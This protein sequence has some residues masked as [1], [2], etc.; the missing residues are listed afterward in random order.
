[1]IFLAGAVILLISFISWFSVKA[2]TKFGKVVKKG[3]LTAFGSS[4]SILLIIG[5]NIGLTASF[6]SLE[7]YYLA[8]IGAGIALIIGLALFAGQ[9]LSIKMTSLKITPRTLSW[10]D[11]STQGKINFYNIEDYNFVVQLDDQENIP[12]YG[13]HLKLNLTNG[14]SRKICISCWK[15]PGDLGSSRHIQTILLHYL[16]QVSEIKAQQEARKKQFESTVILQDDKPKRRTYRE[17]IEEAKADPELLREQEIRQQVTEAQI[18]EVSDLINAQ[19]KLSVSWVSRVTQLSEDLVIEIA[20]VILGKYYHNGFIVSDNPSEYLEPQI[21]Y[22]AKK[23]QKVKELVDVRK[24]IS[25]AWLSKSTGIPE[26][27]VVD[28]ATRLLGRLF[29]NGYIISDDIF[30]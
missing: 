15:T 3:A 8:L 21:N 25:V 17:S 14:T 1:M 12:E 23:I 27:Q 7:V 28:I 4:A 18:S 19:K 13:G 16:N 5:S 11:G 2:S 26:H 6:H 30:E 24:K 20:T 10:K 9:A 29:V 22:P